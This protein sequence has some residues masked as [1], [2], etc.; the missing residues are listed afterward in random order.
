MSRWILVLLAL[1][2]ACRGAGRREQSGADTSG[3]GSPGMP[4]MPGM[5][6]D[7]T[8]VALD[9]TAATRLGI[10]FAR[11][12]ERPVRPFVR[13]VGVL[14]YAEPRR[15]YV[16]ARVSGWVEQLYADYVGKRVTAG[17]PLLAL[18][19]PDLVSAQ[20]EYLL[21]RR[22]G[23][24]TLMAVAR[25]RLGL[26]NVPEDQIDS[27]GVRGTAT[28]TLLL[29]APRSGEIAEKMVIE[30]QA[31]QAGDNLFQIADRSVLWVDLAIF[32]HDAPAVRVGTP[33]SVTVDALPGRTFHGRVTFI[34]PQLDDKTRTLTARIE[35]GNPRGDLR[36][37][38]Y[39]AAEL[40]PAGRRAVTVPLTAVL[41]TGTKDIVF[42]NRGDGRFLP[43]EVRVGLR[44]DSLVEIV[45]GLK[46]GEEVV[47]SATFLLDSES[48][49]AAAIQGIMLQMG[50][51][52]DMGGMRM[53][54]REGERRP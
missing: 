7:S 11:A 12:A 23:D 35:V 39:A 1:V 20:E 10:T 33:A 41:P 6:V 22:L 43:R 51:G 27:L 44:S 15:V 42:V 45:E 38:M 53:P 50:M 31:V 16:N 18:Y 32:E 52:L 21:A 37:G 24:D 30:G 49:L 46:P 19:S 13:A 26:W 29:R 47:A 14:A 3:T 36:P 8:G 54:A 25:R 48:N 17:E 4:G 40:S 34:N 2:G 5:E 28:R 9:R